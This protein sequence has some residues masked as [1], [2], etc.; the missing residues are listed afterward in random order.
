MIY[1]IWLVKHKHSAYQ[2]KHTKSNGILCVH[3]QLVYVWCV[4][5]DVQQIF[6]HY[7]N[8]TIL[9]F[10][11]CCNRLLIYKT[12]DGRQF[13][14]PPRTRLTNPIQNCIRMYNLLMLC[15]HVSK[16]FISY[17]NRLDNKCKLDNKLDAFFIYNKSILFTT[18]TF[19]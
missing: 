7:L 4:G 9:E 17:I 16:C 10:I 5:F 18:Q 1:V 12:L 11:F 14:D 8:K 2:I 6:I 15:W 3:V 19:L 13:Y